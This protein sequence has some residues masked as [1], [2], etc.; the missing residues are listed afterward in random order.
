MLR[1]DFNK[2]QQQSRGRRMIDDPPWQ[3]WRHELL[4]FLFI[5]ESY[6]YVIQAFVIS[7]LLRCH[8]IFM[9]GTK[10]KPAVK[11]CQSKVAS[12]KLITMRGLSI[13]T[14]RGQCNNVWAA[15][16]NVSSVVI[17]LRPT[18]QT[19]TW[20]SCVWYADQNN[21]HFV[22][23]SDTLCCS[24]S[25]YSCLVDA[26]AASASAL[27]DDGCALIEGGGCEECWICSSIAVI[28]AW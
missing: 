2:Q 3:V 18:S 23:S 6:P 25:L 7:R 22:C 10:N 20:Y 9:H 1:N 11:A 19:S 27:A 16:I 21:I 12:S 17:M 28:H 26:G 15:Y 5:W 13:W 14:R 24:S 4:R 8:T